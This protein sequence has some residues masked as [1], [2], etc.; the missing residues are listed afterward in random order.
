MRGES[1]SQLTGIRR[2]V[3]ADLLEAVA[4]HPLRT[5]VAAELPTHEPFAL[6]NATGD[7]PHQQVWHIDSH[8]LRKCREFRCIMPNLGR[9]AISVQRQDL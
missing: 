1:V 5:F 2:Q 4:H 8:G 7:G 9:I 3:H 6:S